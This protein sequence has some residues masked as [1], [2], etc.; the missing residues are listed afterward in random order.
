MY[1][2]LALVNELPVYM[3][4]FLNKE[5]RRRPLPLLNKRKMRQLARAHLDDMGVQLASVG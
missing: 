5:L 4:M 1:Q 2:D 3:N